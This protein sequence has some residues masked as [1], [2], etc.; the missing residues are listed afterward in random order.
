MSKM[1]R[2]ILENQTRDE[3]LNYTES[4]SYK[5]NY[6]YSLLIA[7]ISVLVILSIG[8]LLLSH[9]FELKRKERIKNLIESYS[10]M[11]NEIEIQKAYDEI[12]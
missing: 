12:R 4:K 7:I 9:A 2:H 1:G 3:N 11:S 6:D 10:P 8:Y 5:D